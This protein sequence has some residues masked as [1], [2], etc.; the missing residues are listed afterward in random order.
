[1]MKRLLFCLFV[2][3]LGLPAYAADLQVGD[4]AP[5]F[6]AAS[7]QGIIKLADFSSKK[8]VVLAFYFKDFTPV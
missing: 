6:E 1:M 2:L 8:H 5:L 4:K 3:L 7:T